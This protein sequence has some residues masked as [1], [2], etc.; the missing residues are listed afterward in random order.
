MR[1]RKKNKHESPDKNKKKLPDW[2][3]KKNARKMR[4]ELPKKEKLPE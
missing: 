4:L 2:P 1:R 3:K